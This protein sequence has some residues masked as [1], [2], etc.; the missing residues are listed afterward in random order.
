MTLLIVEETAAMCRLIRS[1][2]ADLPA[3]VIECRDPRDVLALCRAL[4]PDWVVIDLD[5]AGADALATVREVRHA[6]AAIR[7]AVLGEDSARVR[8]A[9]E[10]AGA[11]LYLPKENLLLLAPLLAAERA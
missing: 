10:R 3:S 8:E 4:R 11:R 6:H 2:V 7:V 1:V 9:A 5:L